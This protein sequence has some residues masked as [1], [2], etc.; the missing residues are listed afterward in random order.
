MRLER[1]NRELMR[2][3]NVQNGSERKMPG[4]IFGSVRLCRQ[5]MSQRRRPVTIVW[6]DVMGTIEQRGVGGAVLR[7]LQEKQEAEPGHRAKGICSRCCRMRGRRFGG[8]ACRIFE[9]HLL[10]R[11]SGQECRRQVDIRRRESSLAFSYIRRT[12]CGG[13]RA[14]KPDTFKP[15][16]AR[17]NA[18]P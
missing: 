8:S 4:S 9:R 13:G 12:V 3:R 11:R 10:Y 5:E 6:G 14:C 17:L 18:I 15:G 7:S 1:V 16:T 2:K